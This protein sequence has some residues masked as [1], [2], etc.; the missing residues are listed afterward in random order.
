[1]PPSPQL[2]SRVS[3]L[4]PSGRE[5]LNETDVLPVGPPFLYIR[6][7]AVFFCSVSV[8][9]APRNVP[10]RYFLALRVAGYQSIIGPAS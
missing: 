1:M 7:N 8:A 2:A 3:A 9:P 6:L 4:L 5:F 10:V